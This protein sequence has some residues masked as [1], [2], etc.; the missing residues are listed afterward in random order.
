MGGSCRASR[1]RFALCCILAFVDQPNRT[2]RFTTTADGVDIAFWEIGE[3]EPVVILNNLPICHAD[4]E[5]T[6]PSMASFYMA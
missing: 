6:V 5:W 1:Q 4:L 3:G 2:I